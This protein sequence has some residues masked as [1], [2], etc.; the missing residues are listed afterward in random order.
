MWLPPQ[1]ARRSRRGGPRSGPTSTARRPRALPLRAPRAEARPG[2][3]PR[4]PRDTAATSPGGTSTRARLVGNRRIALDV[5]CDR[6]RRGREGAREHHPEALAPQSRSGQ[7]ARRLELGAQVVL[8][9]PAEEID[10]V[11]REPLPARE[12]AHGQR[13]G[14]DDAKA[15]LGL[16]PHLRP[17]AQKDLQ[18]LAPLVAADEDDVAVSPTRVG[19]FGEQDPVRDH[20]HRPAGVRL[21]RPP[22]ELGHRDPVIGPID[23]DSPRP[24]GQRIPAELLAGS[25]EGG[26]R[27]AVGDDERE[28]GE[29]RRVRLVHVDDVE[30]LLRE[31]PPHPQHRG[32]GENDVRKRGVRRH[33]HR[34]PH[35]DDVIRRAGVPAF[36]RVQEPRQAPRRI[37]THEDLGLDTETSERPR[38]VVS[39]LLDSPPKR[40]GVGHDNAHLHGKTIP[41]PPPGRRVQRARRTVTASGRERSTRH[42][43]QAEATPA[44]PRYP[45]VQDRRN[46]LVL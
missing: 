24:P 18:A 35:R 41:G 31:D 40:P 2:E 27:R 33:D 11:K 20:L 15:R 42:R 1:A 38:L 10:P 44:P 37:V 32:R 7:Q 16:S 30:A 12:P 19:V 3:A 23:R 36:L 43:R 46:S 29:D 8:R 25:V 28:G 6:G 13:V 5:G 14:A 34:P 9:Q 22:R 39:V 45:A 21:G 4:S 26:D 17:R